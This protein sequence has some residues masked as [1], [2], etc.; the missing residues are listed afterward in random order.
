LSLSSGLALNVIAKCAFGINT[1]AISNPDTPIIKEGL[2]ALSGFVPKTWFDT[3]VFSLLVSYFPGS[4]KYVDLLP[5]AWTNLWTITSD[6]MKQREDQNITS[7]DFI[8]RY[9]CNTGQ[10]NIFKCVI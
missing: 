3:I 7:K 6:I 9:N 8:A 5:K 2:D 10:S 1:D 4:T